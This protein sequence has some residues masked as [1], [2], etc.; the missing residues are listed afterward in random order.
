MEKS[1]KMISVIASGTVFNWTS[2]NGPPFSLKP[3]RFAGPWNRYS[4]KAIP[5]LICR[6]SAAMGFR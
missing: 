5:Q 4:K 1:I 6:A 3:I 2:V